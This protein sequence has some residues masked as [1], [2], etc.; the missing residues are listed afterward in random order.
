MM[1]I[2]KRVKMVCREVTIHYLNASPPPEV[3]T[4][5]WTEGVVNTNHPVSSTQEPS[6]LCLSTSHTPSETN[7]DAKQHPYQSTFNLSRPTTITVCRV[8]SRGNCRSRLQSYLRYVCFAN[9]SNSS[10][11]QNTSNKPWIRGRE[12]K[13]VPS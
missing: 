9:T 4:V 10:Q 7:L 8:T 13:V 12:D 2:S 5:L 6:Y 1:E 3:P 11:S